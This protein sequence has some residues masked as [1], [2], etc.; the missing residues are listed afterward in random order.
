M[1]PWTKNYD[2]KTQVKFSN[3]LLPIKEG[4]CFLPSGR[5]RLPYTPLGEKGTKLPWGAISF[6][7][8]VFKHLTKKHK[9]QICPNQTFFYTIGKPLKY[10]YLKWSFIFIWSYELKVMGE[11]KT[12]IKFP[13]SLLPQNNLIP[14][15]LEGEGSLIPFSLKEKTNFFPQGI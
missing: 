1:W 14:F 13:S 11:K 3:P 15:S 4:N 6:G 5:K 2:K 10:K 12:R 9:D 7:E 8:Q